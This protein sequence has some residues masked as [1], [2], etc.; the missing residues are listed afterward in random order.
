[1]NDLPF[2]RTE[3]DTSGIIF[4]SSCIIIIMYHHH[5]VSSSSCII[6]IIQVTTNHLHD[7][8]VLEWGLRV[9]THLSLEKG[10]LMLLLLL[11]LLLLMQMIS[12]HAILIV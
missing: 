2:R 8:I 10:M 12:R 1:M 6:I 5:H 3:V 4:T 11:L 7:E 9:L